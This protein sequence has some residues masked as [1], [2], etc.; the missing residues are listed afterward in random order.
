MTTSAPEPKTVKEGNTICP[1]TG[2]K[3][4]EGTNVNAEYKGRIYNLC[5]SGCVE[6]FKKNRR[7]M[8]QKLMIL[9]LKPFNLNSH[10][11][12]SQSKKVIS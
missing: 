3:I 8:F 7:N 11:I 6:E 2:E 9:N 5:Y 4:E 10:Q 1:V 12:Q